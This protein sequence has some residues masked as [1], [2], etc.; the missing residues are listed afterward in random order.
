MQKDL[1]WTA[2]IN[3]RK[4]RGVLAKFWAYLRLFFKIGGLR[5]DSGKTGGFFNKNARRIGT[6]GFWPLDLDL[7]V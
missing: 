4:V 1:I 6:H 5:V 7:R 3:I 2:G